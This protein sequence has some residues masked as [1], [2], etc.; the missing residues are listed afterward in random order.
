MRNAISRLFHAAGCQKDE[1]VKL[2]DHHRGKE[3]VAPGL[4]SV[5]GAAIRIIQAPEDL[6]ELEPACDALAANSG[7]PMQDLAWIRRF[8][9]CGYQEKTTS[10]L[11]IGYR[12]GAIICF[13][14]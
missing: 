13:C 5:G 14:R 9:L 1:T 7:T 12:E 2:P 6:D 11:D 4:C 10:L 3:R 8:V